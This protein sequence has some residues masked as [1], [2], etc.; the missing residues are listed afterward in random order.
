LDPSDWTVR[1]EGERVCQKEGEKKA[2]G[3]Q[4]GSDPIQSSDDMLSMVSFIPPLALDEFDVIHFIF[5]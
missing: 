3:A 4:K 1:I 2:S 5:S